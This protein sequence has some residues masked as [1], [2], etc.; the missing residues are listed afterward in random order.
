[1]KSGK[2][3]ENMTKMDQQIIKDSLKAN[4]N[5]GPAASGILNSNSARKMRYGTL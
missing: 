5:R 4:Q 2:S 1:M 3:F